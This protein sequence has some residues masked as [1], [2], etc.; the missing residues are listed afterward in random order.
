MNIHFKDKELFE[1]LKHATLA[2]VRIGSHL[3]GT[4]DSESDEDFLHIYATSEKELQSF[5]WTNH[6]LQ[7][8][9]DGNDHNFISLHA[10]IR[11]CVNGDSTINF[12]VIHSTELIGT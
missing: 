1:N 12:E 4:N 8:K 2:K 9:T 7:Y 10:F 3:Y 5:I 6:Q 11:N